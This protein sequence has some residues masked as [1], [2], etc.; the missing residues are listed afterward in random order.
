MV[1]GG[2]VLPGYIVC[3]S[4]SQR[5]EVAGGLLAHPEAQRFIDNQPVT[6]AAIKAVQRLRRGRVGAGGME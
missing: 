2:V 3:E 4:R 1:T 6:V 5:L